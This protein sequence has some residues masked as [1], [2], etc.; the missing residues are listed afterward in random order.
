MYIGDK[1]EGVKKLYNKK[2][3]K[4]IWKVLLHL[5]LEWKKILNSLLIMTENI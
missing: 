4:N 3:T 5:T 2:L 1:Y